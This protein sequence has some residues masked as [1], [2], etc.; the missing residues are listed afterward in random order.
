LCVA[1]GA[2]FFY[3]AVAV[4]EGRASAG[5]W[6]LAFFAAAAGF[7]TD[8]SVFVLLPLALLLV[9]FRIDRK[10]SQKALALVPALLLVG[11]ATAYV[12]VLLFPLRVENSFRLVKEGLAAGV[13]RGLSAIFAWNDFS[14]RFVAGFVDSFYLKFGWMAF[15][16]GRAIVLAWRALLAAAGAGLALFLIT[17]PF[18]KRAGGR[19]ANPVLVRAALFSLVALAL[20]VLGVRLSSSPENIYAQG[21]Y[22]FPVL[23]FGAVL[24]ALGTQTAVDATGAAVRA[25]ARAVAGKTGPPGEPLHA[26]EFALK[27]LAVPALFLLT[28]VIWYYIVPVFHM[29]IKAPH[30]GL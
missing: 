30:N 5:H 19:R 18:A 24:F 7:L 9:A 11:V 10:N 22:L 13:A 27:A 28:I 25:V 20:Q 12:L 4:F 29:T 8:K 14:R 26:G 23:G 15:P 1:L 2:A 21:R 16:A 3:A 17:L 6:V